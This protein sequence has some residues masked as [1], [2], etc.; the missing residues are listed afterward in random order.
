MTTDSDEPDDNCWLLRRILEEIAVDRTEAAMVR[1]EAFRI[2]GLLNGW[3]PPTEED[4]TVNQELPPRM[5]ARL[6]RLLAE[7]DARRG[8]DHH[9]EEITTRSF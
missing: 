4:F 8:G 1:L 3:C 6:K 5:L 9:E 2:L 7:S